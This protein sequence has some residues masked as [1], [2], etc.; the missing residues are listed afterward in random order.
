MQAEKKEGVGG[1]GGEGGGGDVY[2]LQIIYIIGDEFVPEVG[3]CE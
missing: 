1:R 2:S 3:L